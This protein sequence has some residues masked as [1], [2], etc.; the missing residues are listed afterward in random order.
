M[1]SLVYHEL[2][3][4]LATALLYL[5]IAADRCATGGDEPARTAVIVAQGE[6]RRLKGIVDRVVELEREGR[7]HLRPERIDLG[8]IVRQTVERSTALTASGSPVTVVVRGVLTSLWD[9]MAV[10]QIVTNLVSNALKFGAGRPI[11]V[12]VRATETGA[13]ITVR[14]EGCGIP[15]DEHRRIFD[16]HVCAPRTEGGGLGLGLWLVRELAVAHGG[17]VTVSSRPGEGAT[18]HI[19]LRSLQPELPVELPRVPL[20]LPRFARAPMIAGAGRG[21][22]VSPR[23]AARERRPSRA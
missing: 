17:S 10:E 16:R 15:V 3:T 7:P 5:R 19:V 13:R 8:E 22:R 9:E 4:P 20:P 1:S 21:V 11:A 23:P 18:F 6:V 2:S 12:Q 14:D